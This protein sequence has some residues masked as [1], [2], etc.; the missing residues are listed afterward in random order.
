MYPSNSNPFGKRNKHGSKL[1]LLIVLTLVLSSGL[2]TMACVSSRAIQINNTN[3]HTEEAR[4]AENSLFL[5]LSESGMT[6]ANAQAYCQQQGGRLPLINNS[7]S[8]GRATL[9]NIT[10]D[11]FG[12]LGDPWPSELQSAHYWTG[13]YY[14][15]PADDLV[16]VV[17]R[18]G[19]VFI[20][21]DRQR[22]LNRVVCVP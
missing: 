4:L 19:T 2:L 9:D 17:N 5:A 21:V 8:W 1:A 15:V 10:I 7:S 13:T 22:T 3:I 11:G 16:V 12:A 6:W 18:D 20:A 14:S